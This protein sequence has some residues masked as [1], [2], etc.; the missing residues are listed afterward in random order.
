MLNPIEKVLFKLSTLCFSI[1]NNVNSHLESVLHSGT[2]ST[3]T[4]Q[5]YG[6]NGWVIE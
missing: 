4:Y 2:E 5:Y 3:G 6:T 1:G